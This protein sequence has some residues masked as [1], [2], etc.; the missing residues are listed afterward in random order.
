MRDLRPTLSQMIWELV[1]DFETLTDS[2][3]DLR[4]SFGTWHLTWGV[5]HLNLS[6]ES[7][8]Y[9]QSD[10]LQ[11]SCHCKK[12]K[13]PKKNARERNQRWLKGWE[14]IFRASRGSRDVESVSGNRRCCYITTNPPCALTHSQIVV[15]YSP[16]VVPRVT[17]FLPT[18]LETI[19]SLS[20]CYLAYEH[21]PKWGR[22]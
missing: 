12:K 22:Q 2:S 19:Y 1:W 10:A 21:W 4:L 13:K 6:G 16:L 3:L 8:N 5:L 11:Y 17:H 7:F 20:F 15:E 18:R 14:G 9:K